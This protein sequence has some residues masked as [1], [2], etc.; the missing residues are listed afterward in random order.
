VTQAGIALAA[1]GVIGWSLAQQ[2]WQLFLAALVSGAGW[3]ATSGA[4]INSMVAPWFD[5]DRAKALSLAF[6][7]ASMGGVVF[8]PLWTFMIAELG[9][10]MAAAILG[11]AMVA[12]SWLLAARYLTPQ[13]PRRAPE[14]VHPRSDRTQHTGT[15]SRV[16]L[17]GDRRFLTISI[18]FAFGLFAQIGILAHS[19]T[20]LTPELGGNGAAWAVSLITAAA[21]AGR[22]VLGWT[23]RKRS[24]RIAAAANFLVQA[25]GS[26]LLVVSHTAPTLL[27]GCVLFGVGVGNLIS[28]PPIIVQH[29]F[30]AADFGRVVALITAVNQLVFA[31]A[32]AVLGALRDLSDSYA[33]PFTVAMLIQIAAA[34]VVLSYRPGR[35]P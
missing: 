16:D 2:P 26:A 10:S 20:R 11:A 25:C 29:E 13:P 28:L 12:I 24:V 21:V 22:T 1:V 34:P 9:F 4:A 30:E 35:L 5:K 7:G 14:N 17:A 23:L 32:P 27:L 3:A 19:V 31:S 6:N 8:V 18:A 33:L 15:L